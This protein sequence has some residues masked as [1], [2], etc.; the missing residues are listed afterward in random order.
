M[1][2]SK[3]AYLISYPSPT[4]SCNVD[5]GLPGFCSYYCHRLEKDKLPV[6]NSQAFHV[7]VCL[8]LNFGS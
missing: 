6:R 3:L 7:L 1:Q 2:M 5:K 4:K 8:V